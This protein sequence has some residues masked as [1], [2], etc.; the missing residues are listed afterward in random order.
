MRV[1]KRIEHILEEETM[2]SQPCDGEESS[3][4]S[5]EALWKRLNAV[6]DEAE[7]L[8][9]LL[10]TNRRDAAL[11]CIVHLRREMSLAFEH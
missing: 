2:N 11:D 8:L 1:R 5:E 3:P 4:E 9:H 6:I 7:R 10:P